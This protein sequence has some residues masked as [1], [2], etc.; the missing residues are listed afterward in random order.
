[1][2]SRHPVS[3]YL[4]NEGSTRRVAACFLA[5]GEEEFKAGIGHLL[6]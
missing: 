1:M 5:M 3:I 2:H 4:K 6:I